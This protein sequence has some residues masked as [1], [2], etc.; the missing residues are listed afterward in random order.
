MKNPTNKHTRRNVARAVVAVAAV[1]AAVVTGASFYML[2]YSLSADSHRATGEESF[3][4]FCKNYPA[5]Q[6]WADSLK[7]A[8]ALRDTTITM[9]GGERQHAI[10]VRS[11]RAYGRTALLVHGYGDS[12]YGML[13]IAYIYNKVM[14]MNVLL[15]DLHAHGQSDGTDIQMGWNDRLDIMHWAGVAERMFRCKG[16]QSQM[17]VHGVSMGAAT[18]MCVSG[19]HTPSYMR[20]FVEDCGYTSVWDEFHHELGKRFHLPDFPLM[21]TTSALC[22]LRYGWSFGEASPLRQVAKCR[23]PMLFIHGTADDFVPTWMVRPLYA[24]K[25]QPKALWL[26]PGSAHAVA[27]RDHPAEYT[28]RVTAF[29]GKYIR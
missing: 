27:Y 1:V 10:F 22:R 8:G 5:L 14:G 3:S 28:R 17:V 7:R 13:H 15:P 4:Y 2:S 25:P 24:A 29:V 12:S 16:R 23:K 11:P 19:E 26:A 21:Y 18:T 9:N 20:C 6:P